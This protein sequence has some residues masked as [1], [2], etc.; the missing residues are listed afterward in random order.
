MP[1]MKRRFGS[2]AGGSGD[3]GV[4]CGAMPDEIA[5]RDDKL[6][7]RVQKRRRLLISERQAGQ[8][9]ESENLK[10]VAVVVGDAEQLGIGIESKHAVS[11]A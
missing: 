4:N 11:A 7:G 10:A 1:T 3:G 8:L 5:M 9:E 2:A 6:L